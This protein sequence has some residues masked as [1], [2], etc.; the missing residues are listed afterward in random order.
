MESEDW[1]YLSDNNLFTSQT[2]EEGSSDFDHE[3]DQLQ[4]LADQVGGDQ[5]E[6]IEEIN[7][8]C[9]TLSLQAL[10]ETREIVFE[11]EVS[12]EEEN[13]EVEEENSEVEMENSEEEEVDEVKEGD[14]SE[15]NGNDC[16]S[17]V[18]QSVV[19]WGIGALSSVGIAA[20]T[21]TMFM[22]GGSKRAKQNREIQ[23]QDCA[24][25]KVCKFFSSAKKLYIIKFLRKIIQ[26]LLL[27]LP[28]VGSPSM[29]SSPA[30]SL[31]PFLRSSR[32]SV[33]GFNICTISLD[34]YI[35]LSLNIKRFKI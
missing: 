26:N 25:D 12:L 11:R 6:E 30:S 17:G 28:L 13:S 10:L 22:L 35:I 14:G 19:K 9:D 29:A 3:Q 2:T 23:I 16:V 1:E 18:N 4:A 24:D 31:H 34:S 21:L 20:V 32:R 8:E 5:V 33:A 7:E 15:S 27:F